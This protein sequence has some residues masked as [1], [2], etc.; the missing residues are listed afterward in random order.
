M[1]ILIDLTSLSYHIS[2]IE[3]YALCISKEMIKQDKS[4]KYILVFRNDVDHNFKGEIDG[5]R[6][7]AKILHGNNK[8]LFNQIILPLSL[9]TIKADYYLFFAFVSPILFRKKGIISTVHDVGVWDFPQSLTFKQKLYCRVG[10]KVA[11]RNSYKIITVSDF[12]KQRI[13]DILHYP[14]EHIHVVY[15]AISESFNKN[16]CSSFDNVKNKYKLPDKYIMTLSTIE[17]RKNIGLLLDAFEQIADEVNFDVVLVGRKG[18][19]IDEFVSKL[20]KYSR[21]HITGFV[22]DEDVTAIYKNAMCFV[23]P[24]AYEGFGLPPIEALSMGTPVISS[25]AASMPEVLRKQAIFFRNGNVHE[26]AELL[27]NLD[28]TVGCL[29]RELDEFQKK[30]YRFDVSARKILELLK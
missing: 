20:N 19:K 4:S 24:T 15:S 30:N 18:W 10:I 25:D 21:V 29:P 27:R 22:N 3:R 8:L 14:N 7:M 6:V 28:Q 11:A 13:C 5:I 26:L 23:F 2:G 12:S 9:Y 16:T 17:P 1:T